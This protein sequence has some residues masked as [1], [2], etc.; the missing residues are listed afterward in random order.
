MGAD[1]IGYLVVGPNK[2]DEDKKS[3]VIALFDLWAEKTK[4]LDDGD[5]PEAATIEMEDGRMA[6]LDDVMD[7]TAVLGHWRDGAAFVE[8]LWGWWDRGSKDSASREMPGDPTRCIY[9][10]GEMTWGD[11]PEGL[12]YELLDTIMHIPGMDALLGVE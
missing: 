2:L 8:A 6:S 4:G 1:L 5:D 11:T 10:A 12:G 3:A 7:I 9:F